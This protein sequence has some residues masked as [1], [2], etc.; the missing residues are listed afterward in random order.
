MENH[1]NGA[2]TD[3][4]E[5]YYNYHRL[6]LDMMTKDQ[7]AAR[8]AIINSLRNLQ[9]VNKV[10]SN[11]TSVQQFVDVKVQELISI[12]TPAPA[13]E[14]K[15]VYALVKSVSPINAV[16]MKDFENAK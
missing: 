13:A 14:R 9:Q 7:T 5:A 15:Q 8:Q 10:R 12:F 6:G 1:T 16:K 4:H 3:L 2:Y 11:L